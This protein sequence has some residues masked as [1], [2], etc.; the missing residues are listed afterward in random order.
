MSSAKSTDFSRCWDDHSSD[1][2]GSLDIS[3]YSSTPTAMPYRHRRRDGKL[4]SST[5]NEPGATPVTEPKPAPSMQNSAPAASPD[6]ASITQ[7]SIQTN[8]GC[9]IA[10]QLVPP[11]RTL[12]TP[13]SPKQTG[14]P[15]TTG[16]N[17]IEQSMD[18]P[19]PLM[20]LPP[21]AGIGII[22]A[23]ANRWPKSARGSQG[24]VDL[25][26]AQTSP[27]MVQ[28]SP[29][30]S[31]NVHESRMHPSMHPAVISGRSRAGVQPSS[32]PQLLL[33]GDSSVTTTTRT[34]YPKPTIYRLS[35][36]PL[37]GTKQHQNRSSSSTSNS[38]LNETEVLPDYSFVMSAILPYKSRQDGEIDVSVGDEMAIT[39]ELGLDWLIGF[40]L[41][42]NSVIGGFPRTCVTG[43]SYQ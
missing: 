20:G 17:K 3:L 31:N 9:G 43:N 13:Y 5:F 30:L 40:N 21:A 28:S 42:T 10:A 25:H 16:S 1:M 18:S 15:G 36:V 12:S 22:I 4:M 14:S 2:I 32:T 35:V 33:E 6:L 38:L 37:R 11:A 24:Y 26:D 34:A 19:K 41:T 29:F 23:T 27:R 8:G 39:D 7:S